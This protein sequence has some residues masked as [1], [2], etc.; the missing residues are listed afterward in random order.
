MD[1]RF[2]LRVGALPFGIRSLDQP[3]TTSI[4]KKDKLLMRDKSCQAWADTSG[5]RSTSTENLHGSLMNFQEVGPETIFGALRGPFLPAIDVRY[6]PALLIVMWIICGLE[7]VTKCWLKPKACNGL[8]MP[9][10]PL[11]RADAHSIYSNLALK[12]IAK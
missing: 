4:H 11:G 7:L 3:G 6:R 8:A 1:E 10:G 5:F 9:L 12:I 2:R